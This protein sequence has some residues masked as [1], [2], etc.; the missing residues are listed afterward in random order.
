MVI[1]PP[2]QKAD[3]DRREAGT[4]IENPD[5]MSPTAVPDRRGN[6]VHR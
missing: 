2:S 4:S 1:L 6:E 3:A 5:A